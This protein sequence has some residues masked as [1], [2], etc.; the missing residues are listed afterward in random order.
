MPKNVEKA[1]VWPK[2]GVKY[3]YLPVGGKRMSAIRLPSNAEGEKVRFKELDDLIQTSEI[4]QE[5]S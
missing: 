3:A 1:L 5:E 2:F 4:F